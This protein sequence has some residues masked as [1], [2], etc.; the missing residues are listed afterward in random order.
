LQDFILQHILGKTNTKANV[1]SRKDQVD[2][3]EVKKDI[4][5]LKDRL[6]TRRVT[7][8]VEMIIIRRN[9]IIRRNQ[10]KPNKRIENSEEIG[11]E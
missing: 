2:I 11:K 7:T 4:K 1:L 10:K 3:K 5:L 6:W 8:E 9:H